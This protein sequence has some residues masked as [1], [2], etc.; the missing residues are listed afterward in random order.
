MIKLYSFGSPNV[1][2]IY[3]ALEELGLPYEVEAVDVLAAKQ[4]DP[5][6][7]ELNPNGKVPVIVDSEGPEGAPFTCF[8]SGAILMY[9]AEKTGRLM[10]RSTAARYETLQWMMVQLTAVGPSFGQCIHFHR[11][12][13]SDG[14]DYARSR[15]MTQVVRVS[16]ALERRLA[17]APWLSGAEYGIAD[18]ATWPWA[19][20]M[21]RFLSAEVVARL[22]ATTRWLGTVGERPA[23]KAALARVEEFQG[24]VTA[25][26]TATPQEIDRFFARGQ[27]AVA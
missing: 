1:V 25:L 3:I 4:F 21:P 24:R 12:A 7:L 20:I 27:Y 5:A 17:A 26:A 15:Y 9:L 2:K 16:E 13:P 19:R 6:F 23:V 8:E 14:N 22:P 10:P 11:F 18:V